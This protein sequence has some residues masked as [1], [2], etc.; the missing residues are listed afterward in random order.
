MKI[1]KAASKSTK[2]KKILQ[3]TLPCL[4]KEEENW[5]KK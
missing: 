5:M 3:L 2:K 1:L 4:E